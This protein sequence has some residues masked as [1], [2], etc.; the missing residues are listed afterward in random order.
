MITILNKDNVPTGPFTR[1]QVE[2][3]LKSGECKLTDL[4][5]REGLSQWTPLEQVLAKDSVAAPVAP[6]VFV[7]P[8]A[9]VAGPPSYS[10]AATMKPPGHLLYGGFWLRF[11]AYIIDATI[12]TI[13]IM[14]ICIPIFAIMGGFAAIT[15]MSHQSSLSNNND[16]PA[17]AVF[18]VAFILFELLIVGAS[19]VI[20]WLYYAYLESGP[21]QATFGKRV[22][23]LKVTNMA[24]ERISFGHASGRFFGK[25]ITGLIPFGIGYMMAGFTERK[26]ALHDLVAGTLVVRQ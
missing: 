3:K 10:Y 26:Q 12:L 6:P 16:N 21:H 9:P 1:E 13:P 22:M 17:A 7:P 20:G 19:A 2:Q 24:G 25:I 15:A 23:S 11:V 14:V 4:A 5:F 8:T 18:P